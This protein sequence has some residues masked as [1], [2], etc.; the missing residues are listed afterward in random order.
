[1][2]WVIFYYCLYSFLNDVTVGIL[3]DQATELNDRISFVLLSVFTVVEFSL[4]SVAIRMILK[5]KILR[6]II[7][8][9][10]PLFVIFAAI[11]FYLSFKSSIDSVSITVEYIIIIIFSLFYFYEEISIPNFTFIYNSSRFWIIVGILTYST[12]TFFF[13]LYS[14]SM[15]GQDWDNWSIINFIFTILKNILFCIA[16]II[17]TK[18]PLHPLFPELEEYENLNKPI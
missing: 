14:S 11:V 8:I 7:K 18:V 3:T 12:G 10:F 17:A 9:S 1:M 5:K 13:F 2:L 16:I 15:L 4:F 6:D